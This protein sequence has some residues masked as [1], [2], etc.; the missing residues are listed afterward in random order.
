MRRCMPLF[1]VLMLLTGALALGC[2]A[3]NPQPQLAGSLQE[4]F[5]RAVLCE[6]QPCALRPRP[7]APKDVG[8]LRVE[9]VRFTPEEGHDAVAVVFRP[10]AEAKYPAVIVQHFLGGDKDHIALA[11]LM[12]QLAQRGFLV[13]A[14]DGRHRGERQNG[15]SLEAAMLEA[16]R[17]GKG[18][19]FLIDTAY[20]VLRLVD[21][22][23]ERPDVDAERI[24]MT[25]ISEGGVLTWMCAAADERIKVAVPIIGVTSF[26]EALRQA[27]GPETEA[28]VRLFEAVL[29]E[30]AKDLG[31]KEANGR[32]LREAWSRL[33]PGM[34]D[35]FDAPHVVPLIA[36]RPL[37]IL[38]HEEDELFPAAGARKVH[39]AAKVRY[40]QLGA[41]D[42]LELQVT[43]GL[44]HSAF[45]LGA[46]N[47]MMQ[48]MERWLKPSAN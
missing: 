26:G 9:R 18:R 17:T 32:V 37:L 41:A 11:A 6:R 24:G 23:Q 29:K 39:A 38:N 48:W 16:L 44:K 3:E 8:N 21:Y 15:K 2:R 10:K 36:P 5:R 19:P 4:E 1:A 31:E 46:M 14:I 25:G 12:P 40:A 28:R 47:A 30:Y 43:P 7:G 22:L 27:E 42:R 34:L 20:D 13:A 33:V 45:N 35:R